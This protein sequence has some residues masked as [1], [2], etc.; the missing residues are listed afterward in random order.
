MIEM[1][2]PQR[3]LKQ[4]R[5]AC[6]RSNEFSFSARQEKSFEISSAVLYSIVLVTT[7]VQPE[8]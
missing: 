2:L 3:R 8:R 7:P 6:G 5:M 1:A 4:Q